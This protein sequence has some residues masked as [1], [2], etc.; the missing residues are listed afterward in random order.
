MTIE[1]LVLCALPASPRS[2]RPD[3]S[4]AKCAKKRGG[5]RGGLLLTRWIPHI[6]ARAHCAQRCN[7]VQENDTRD[8]DSSIAAKYMNQ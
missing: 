2:L 5:R 6:F 3:F 1:R 8:G 7:T 4:I